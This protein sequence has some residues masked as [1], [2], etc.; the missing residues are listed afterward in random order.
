LVEQAL[1]VPGVLGSRMTGGGFGGCTVTLVE[2]NAVRILEMHL[3]KKYKEE[4]DI[5]CDCYEC[6]PSP[7]AGDFSSLLPSDSAQDPGR[8]HSTSR[9]GDGGTSPG[10]ILTACVVG[11]AV[12]TLLFWYAGSS[13]RKL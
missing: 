9:V 5:D 11:V 1:E 4:Y 6:L 13:S 7:G 2:R 3:K 10:W 12:G 8:D